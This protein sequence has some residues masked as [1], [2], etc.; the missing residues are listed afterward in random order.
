MSRLTIGIAFVVIG[1]IVSPFTNIF[2]D[3]SLLFI[4]GLAF[5]S[6]I[7]CLGSYIFNIPFDRLK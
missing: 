6:G 7:L 5:G 3:G 1:L 2:H 4:G